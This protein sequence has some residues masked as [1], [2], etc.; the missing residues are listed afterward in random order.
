MDPIALSG[1]TASTFVTAVGGER[2][3]ALLACAWQERSGGA[4]VSG[5]I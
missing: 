5:D 3:A 1:P 2:P 4:K